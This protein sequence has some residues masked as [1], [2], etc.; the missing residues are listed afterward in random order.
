MNALKTKLLLFSALLAPSLFAHPGHPG[1]ADHGDVTH[2]VL[3]LLLALPL[4]GTAWLF[5]RNQSRRRALQPVR[6]E[7]PRG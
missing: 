2:A 3:G 4:L 7:V 6:K 1:P 5:L